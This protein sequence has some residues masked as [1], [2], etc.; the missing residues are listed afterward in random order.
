MDKIK[1]IRL[2]HRMVTWLMWAVLLMASFS[3]AWT[4]LRSSQDDWWH[5]KTGKWIVEN[6]ILPTYDIFTYT[7]EQTLWHNHEWLSQVVFWLVYCQWGGIFGLITFKALVVTATFAGVAWLAYNRC[8]SWIIALVLAWV[9]AEIS[10][11][12][13]YIRPPIFSYALFAL[14]IGLFDAWRRN[15]ISQ[16]VLAP[17][18]IVLMILWANLHGMCLL[19]IIVAGAYAA[20][21]TVE[22]FWNRHKHLPLPARSRLAFIWCM[23]VA[24]TLAAMCNPSGYEL[25]FLGGKFMNDPYLKAAIQEMLPAPFFLKTPIGGGPLSFV[26]GFA[27]FWI[28]VT[29]FVVLLLYKRRLSCWADLFLSVFCVLQAVLHWRLLPLFAIGCAG[30][31]AWL[32]VEILPKSLPARRKVLCAIATLGIVGAGCMTMLVGEPPPQTYLRRNILLARGQVM[33]SASYPEPIVKFIEEANLP[34]RMFSPSNY[35]GYFMWRLAPEKHKLFTDNRYDIWGSRWYL[36]HE[37]ILAGSEAKDNILGRSWS[38]LLDAY[39]VNFVVINRDAPLH[40]KLIRNTRNSSA[41]WIQVYYWIPVGTGPMGGFSVWLRNDGTS[42]RKTV[43]D[44]SL[45][46]F[47]EDNPGR[48]SP[49]EFLY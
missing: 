45:T 49:T 40:Q 26:P 4:P 34:D 42:E 22:W 9:A 11:R 36:E 32:L 13:I 39:G 5:L 47:R 48:P 15:R 41:H 27:A 43:I 33:E 20:G 44:R 25:F 7:G 18:V 38:D 21:E 14:Y 2:K 37:V 17:V 3:Y 19:G 29:G 1:T 12:A 6:R 28:A 30:P 16:K 31:G 24:L 23:P 46:L 35:C 8:R 10:R